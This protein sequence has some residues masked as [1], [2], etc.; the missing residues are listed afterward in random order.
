MYLTGEGIEDDRLDAALKELRPLPQPDLDTDDREDASNERIREIVREE[1][2][3]SE[4]SAAG[5]ARA[6]NNQQSVRS[7]DDE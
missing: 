7:L 1:L 2:A 4:G 6:E 5:S 3:Q